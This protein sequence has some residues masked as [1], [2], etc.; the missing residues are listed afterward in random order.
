VKQQWRLF[1]STL[2]QRRGVVVVVNLLSGMDSR[3]YEGWPGGD[4]EGMLMGRRPQRHDAKAEAEGINT[5]V[6]G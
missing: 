4:S 3:L 6:T 5:L 1:A 2:Q